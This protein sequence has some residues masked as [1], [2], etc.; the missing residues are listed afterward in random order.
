MRIWYQSFV[1]ARQQADYIDRLGA[2][3]ASIADPGVTF[4]VRGMAPPDRALHRLTEFRCAVQLVR[5]AVAAARQGYD[6]V[7]VG[8]FQDSGLYEARSAVD[9]PILGLGEASMLHACTLGG[10]VALVTID[11]VFVPLH[12]EQIAR[13]GLRDRVVAVRAIRTRVDDYLAAFN[14]AAAYAVVRDQF[15][16]QVEP[17]LEAGV[18]VVVPAG[19]LPTLLFLR[20]AAF[21]IGQAVVLNGIAVVAKQAEVAVKLRQLTGLG[22]SRA[23][24]FALPP[25]QALAEF[26][27]AGA[28][29]S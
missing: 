19:G 22:P 29:P 9:L 6:A 5:N 2:Y 14:N 11:P 13:Y 21:T 8:H 4:D 1:D 3:L 7:V 12:E 20:E 17:L 18:E 10:K 25:A 27:E 16:R 28:S 15:V 24:T 26:L 23:A